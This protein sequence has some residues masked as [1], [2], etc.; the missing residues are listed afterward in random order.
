[1]ANTIESFPAWC[2]HVNELYGHGH[3]PSRRLRVHQNVLMSDS[4]VRGLIAAV[5]DD[6]MAALVSDAAVA[7]RRFRRHLGRDLVLSD[8]HALCQA[9]QLHMGLPR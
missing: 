6:G 5:N 4:L 3:T 2:K 1:M 8:Y 9:I 7:L